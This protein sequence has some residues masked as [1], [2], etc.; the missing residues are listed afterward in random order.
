MCVILNILIITFTNP[1]Y[2][3]STLVA[4]KAAVRID[5]RDS[6]ATAEARAKSAW[7]EFIVPLK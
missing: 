7:V 3:G 1:K 2:G 4:A 6:S 5:I